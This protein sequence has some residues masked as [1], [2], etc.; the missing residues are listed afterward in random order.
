M[1]SSTPASQALSN[2]MIVR[3]FV[4]EILNN[5]DD[6]AMSDLVHP[7]YRHLTPGGELRGRDGLKALL[8]DYRSGLPD[9]N[10]L[11]DDLVA[12]GDKVVTSI[13]LTGTHS[14]NFLGLPATGKLLSV[15]GMVLSRLE[16]G[17][18]IEE[19]EIL[20]LLGMFRQLGVLSLPE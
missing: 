20:D 2:E 8:D 19:W 16:D 12:S 11:I 18:I 17:K 9:L 15:H 4:D 1:T 5:D 7:D 14:G 10:V 3:R 13:R 6:S